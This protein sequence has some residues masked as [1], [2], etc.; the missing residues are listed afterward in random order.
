MDE[1]RLEELLANGACSPFE[2]VLRRSDGAAAPVLVGA[3]LL[4]AEPFQWICFVVD[5]TERKQLEQRLEQAKQVE[6]I[7][8][9]AGSVAHDFNNLL[10]SILGNACLALEMLPDGSRTQ[11]GDDDQGPARQIGRLKTALQSENSHA[12]WNIQ[13]MLDHLAPSLDARSLELLRAIALGLG[14]RSHLPAL[15]RFPSWRN[16]NPCPLE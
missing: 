8:L 12:E 2:S 10:T 15:D 13:A 1:R 14:D 9:L 6:R 4:Q 16:A 5:L 7:G 3:T 11:A